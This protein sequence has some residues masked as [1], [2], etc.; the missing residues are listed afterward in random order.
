MEVKHP[1]SELENPLQPQQPNKRFANVKATLCTLA[2][3]IATLYTVGRQKLQ[4]EKKEN[5]TAT[6]EFLKKYSSKIP[7][8]YIPIPEFKFYHAASSEEKVDPKFIGREGIKESLKSWLKDEKTGTGVYLVTGYRGMGKSSFVGK[9]LNEITKKPIK[10]FYSFFKTMIVSLFFALISY[11]IVVNGSNFLLFFLIVLMVFVV[12]CFVFFPIHTIIREDKKDKKD[13]KDRKITWGK[14]FETTKNVAT[15]LFKREK[16]NERIIIKLNLGHETLNERDILSLISNSIEYEYKKYISG[17]GVNWRYFL[18]KWGLISVLTACLSY[19]IIHITHDFYHRHLFNYYLYEIIESIY[20][21][22]ESINKNVILNY[23][24]N[25]LYPFIISSLIYLSF[26]FLWRLVRKTIAKIRPQNPTAIYNRLLDLNQ[27]IISSTNEEV[28]HSGGVGKNTSFFNITIGHRRNRNYLIADVREIEQRLSRILNDIADSSANAPNFIIVFDE[29]DKI[30]PSSNHQLDNMPETMPEFEHSGSGFAGGASSRMRKQNLLKMLANMKYFISTAKVKFIFIAGRELYDAYLADASDREFAVSSI[31]S[32]DVIYV[33]SFLS[34]DHN[35]KDVVSMTEEF[36]CRQLLPK[37]KSIINKIVKTFK[38]EHKDYYTLKTYNKILKSTFVKKPIDDREK[39]KTIIMLYQFAVYLSH[40]S[41]GAPKKLS[42]YFEKYVET[43]DQMEKYKENATKLPD[44]EGTVSKY[45]L[46]FNYRTQQKIGFIHYLAFP[47]SNAILNNASRYGDKLLISACFLT[48]HIYKYHNSGFSWRNLENIPELLNINRAPETREFIDIIISFLKHSHISTTINS[49]YHFKFPMTIAEE[50]SL[51]SRLSEEVS[52]LFNFTLDDSL[53]LNE[54]YSKLL[55]HYSDL[56]NKTDKNNNDLH[57]VIADIHHI[58]GDLHTLDEKY[59]EA[60]FEYQYC[61][62]LLS[63]EYEGVPDNKRNNNP[64]YLSHILNI[65]HIMLKLGLVQEKRKANNSAYVTYNGLITLLTQFRNIKPGE[66]GLKKKVKI[67]DKNTWKEGTDIIYLDNDYY[68]TDKKKLK[69]FY[70][71][72]QAKIEDVDI[73]HFQVDMEELIPNLHRQLSPEKSILANRLSLFEDISLVYQSLLARLFVLEKRGLNGITKENVDIAELDFLYLHRAVYDKEKY[74]IAADFFRKLADI[75]YY[76]NGLINRDSYRFFMLLYLYGYNLEKDLYE[77]F[78]ITDE[79]QPIDIEKNWNRALQIKN[80]EIVFNFEILETEEGKEVFEKFIHEETFSNRLKSIGLDVKEENGKVKISKNNVFDNM[81]K[82]GKR[83]NDLL[84]GYMTNKD[85]PTR[86]IKVKDKKIPCYACKYYYRSLKI[87]RDKMMISYNYIS[88]FEEF[89]IDS[90]AIFFIKMLDKKERFKSLKKNDILTLAASLD[91]MGNSMFSCSYEIDKISKDFL[92]HFIGL[93]N[94]DMND[95]NDRNEKVF[96]TDELSKN[97]LSQIEKAL[98]FYWAASGYFKYSTNKKEE[99]ECYKKILHVFEVYLLIHQ[100]NEEAKEIFRNNLSN[101][102]DL[103]KKATHSLY[104]QFEN[105]NIVEIQKLKG[106]FSEQLYWRV[107]LNL[108]SNYPD[109]EE[110]LIIFCNIEQSCI[111][112]EK[113]KKD[114]QNIQLAAQMY[115]SMPLSSYRIER[116]LKERIVSLKF[117]ADINMKILYKLLECEECIYNAEFPQIF[118]QN[119]YSYLTTK[120]TIVE[121]LGEKEYASFFEEAI[122]KKTENNISE[123]IELVEFLIMDTMF[124]LSKI[125][126]IISPT[127]QTTLFTESYMGEVY[128]KLFEC[129]QMFDFIY[130]M[131]K[132]GGVDKQLEQR[133]EDNSCNLSYYYM[134]KDKICKFIK[135]RLDNNK[136]DEISVEDVDIIWYEIIFLSLND[137]SIKINNSLNEIKKVDNHL[138]DEY[139]EIFVKKVMEYIDKPDFENNITSYPLDMALWKYKRAIEMHHEGA[140]YQE[141]MSN[142]YF[143]EDDLSNNT[144]QFYFAIERYLNN[145]G[146]LNERV[147]RLKKVRNAS[148]LSKMENYIK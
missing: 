41:T 37:K 46:S 57:H 19:L 47:V 125:V 141:F 49:L 100:T 123:K 80:D 8:M 87:I 79:K 52:A 26:F 81:I 31:F 146:L 23:I 59:N 36:I 112:T 39:E 129:N 60:I 127:V 132:W 145:C 101:I 32:S 89:S 107:H 135:Y 4:Q 55:K 108:L 118:Y 122:N 140:A 50:I 105:T 113:N 93:I 117:K 136:K 76:K 6:N 21:I 106:M 84:N 22:I 29:L 67:A 48:N 114:E 64:H 11:C 25:G 54:H 1:V 14:Y 91:G 98:L 75:L 72:V 62:N 66:L 10:G 45:Y 131:Y 20:K 96:W 58:L 147:K 138:D 115:K 78:L 88:E 86:G 28:N 92:K 74:M 139:S 65:V 24:C 110:M 40:V 56:Q 148:S 30:D 71:H 144:F 82:C 7:P 2:K 27:S 73:I 120:K 44:I 3:K 13:K 85:Y 116:T 43:S 121:L 104:M 111:N 133:F 143:L 119:Y 77:F 16:G 15:E 99:L 5:E 90:Q 33:N 70:D 9:V 95:K 53:S 42:N 137:I 103:F 109:I 124:S 83:R 102:K 134:I 61:I 63:K 97:N 130:M 34:R 126:E 68:S 35:E 94:D 12:F 17:K 69:L 18:I 38:I 51:M 128:M 142:M